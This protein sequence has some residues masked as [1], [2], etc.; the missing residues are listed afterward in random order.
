MPVPEVGHLFDGVDADGVDEVDVPFFGA[1]LPFRQFAADEDVEG[2]LAGHEAFLPRVLGHLAEVG[3]GLGGVG[4]G[5][6]GG[7]VFMVAVEGDVRGSGDVE[8][9]GVRPVI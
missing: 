5:G 7:G 6:G 4:A 8:V 2:Q 1:G 9:Q 3:G